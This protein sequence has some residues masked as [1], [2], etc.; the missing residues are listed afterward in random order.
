MRL[1]RPA[2]SARL[3]L[4]VVYTLA[5]FSIA[6][7]LVIAVNVALGQTLE[8]QKATSTTI[9]RSELLSLFG[10]PNEIRIDEALTDAEA[11][12]REQTLANLRLISVVGL[13]GLL[14]LSLITGWFVAGWVLRP[15]DRITEV[16]RDI[17]ATDLSRRIH[18]AGPDDELRRLADTFDG[19]LDRLD[20]SARAQRTF[21]EDASH[22]LRN[23]LAVIRTSLDVALAAPDDSEGL[24]S[25]AEV[26]RRAAD[27]MT[28]TVDDLVAFIRNEAID[29]TRGPVDLSALVAET[30]EEYRALGEE[31]AVSIVV[32]TAP[33]GLTLIA[34]RD[35]L[36]RALANLLANALRIAPPG[37]SVHIGAGRVPGWLWFGVRDFGRGIA[38]DD[39]PLVFRRAWRDG[40]PAT[41][42]A[43]E[44]IGLALVRQ[45]AEAHGGTVSITSAVG[46]G[47]SF[48]VWLPTRAGE[49]ADL[50]TLAMVVCARLAAPSASENRPPRPLPRLRRLPQEPRGRRHRPPT[51]TSGS[52][53]LSCLSV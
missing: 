52:G 23:P 47:A 35:A 49:S 11:V 13:L 34:D 48:V 26:S 36:K 40:H 30:S 3:R 14:P 7:V 27:R 10:L 16:A 25:A 8:T 44:G 21:V 29:R 5:L 41:P 9:I 51:S 46:A 6:T 50:A 42:G 17:G 24:R 33:D 37:T 31:G 22:E 53:R 32:E 45:I 15:I 20:R 18:L 1:R 39:Q 19:M 2:N 28:G 43:S 38:P 12:I 4:A